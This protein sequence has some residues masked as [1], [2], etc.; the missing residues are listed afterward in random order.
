MDWTEALLLRYSENLT[1]KVLAYLLT[2]ALITLLSGGLYG[3]A[4]LLVPL[5][6]DAWGALIIRDNHAA[7]QEDVLENL[8]NECLAA[9]GIAKGDPCYP[10]FEVSGSIDH[11]MLKKLKSDARFSI[12]APKQDAVVIAERRGR[13]F[14]PR[15]VLGKVTYTTEDAGTRDVFYADIVSVEHTG[16]SLTMTTT[17]GETVSYAGQGERAA[18]AVARL[19]ERLR[20]FKSRQNTPEG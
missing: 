11:W 3:F 6:L 14:P 7:F 17:A 2:L 9:C 4:F 13:I 16:K 1:L 20:E 8:E 10:F 12:M 18:Q 5:G 19:R 15:T